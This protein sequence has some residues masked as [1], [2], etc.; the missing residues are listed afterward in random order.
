MTTM[1]NPLTGESNFLTKLANDVPDLLS[2]DS[3]RSLRMY[4]LMAAVSSSRPQETDA[5]VSDIDTDDAADETDWHCH[6]TLD[7]MDNPPLVQFTPFLREF[8]SLYPSQQLLV[9]SIYYRH[10]VMPTHLIV[11]DWYTGNRDRINCKCVSL[12]GTSWTQARGY[13]QQEFTRMR[14]T[15]ERSLTMKRM[16]IM[17]GNVEHSFQWHRFE[18]NHTIETEFRKHTDYDPAKYSLFYLLSPDTANT[19][20]IIQWFSKFFQRFIQPKDEEERVPLLIFLEVVDIPF[21]D[22]NAISL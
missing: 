19:G 2:D 17:R 16:N 12:K 10:L 9:L 22:P 3:V 18:F 11:L 13:T 4:L 21:V 8:E 5:T 20:T 15:A 14:T 7:W 6:E 1:S